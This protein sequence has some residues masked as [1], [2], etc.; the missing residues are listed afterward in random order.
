MHTWERMH[1][2]I[3]NVG[4]KVEPSLLQQLTHSC[5]TISSLNLLIK[6]GRIRNKQRLSQGFQ[7]TVKK[8]LNKP[9]VEFMII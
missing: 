6:S 1:N 4:L 9:C 5:F 7:K 8:S 2:F 3:E